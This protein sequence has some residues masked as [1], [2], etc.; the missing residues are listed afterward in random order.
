MVA[1]MRARIE[2]EQRVLYPLLREIG[3]R[4]FIPP[5]SM[6]LVAQAHR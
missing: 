1:S 6:P 3:S 4:D 2:I 5:A